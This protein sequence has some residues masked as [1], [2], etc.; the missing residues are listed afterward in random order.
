MTCWYCVTM[1]FLPCNNNVTAYLVPGCG[2]RSLNRD[3][4][5]S[6]NRDSSSLGRIP[7]RSHDSER[8]SHS[9]VACIFSR[10]DMPETPPEGG[11]WYR[12][13]NHPSWVLDVEEQQLSA[14]LLTLS[15][16]CQTHVS[17]LLASCYCDNVNS[18]IISAI[19]IDSYEF[20]IIAR[21]LNKHRS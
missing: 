6:L 18:A 13:P 12:R 19:F 2:G 4:W 5:T 15:L 16:P 17:Q 7:R 8:Q 11:V 20:L 21:E 3:S 1:L 10:W 9:S 14:E